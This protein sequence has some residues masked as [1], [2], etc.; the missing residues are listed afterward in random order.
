MHAHLLDRLC[1]ISALIL[2]SPLLAFAALGIKLTS[3]GPVLYHARRVGL[4]G[5]EFTMYKF[6]TMKM[7]KEQ[8]S[9]VTHSH[10]DRIFPFGSFLRSTKIDEL[11]Q[12]WNIVIGQMCIVGPRPED[13]G[14]V[15]EHYTDWQKEVLSVTPGLTSPGSLYDY[16]HG[17]FLVSG[18]ASEDIYLSEVMPRLLALEIVYLRSR[19][20]LTDLGMIGRTLAVILA[21]STGKRHFKLP[22]EMPAALR[23]L[24][25]AGEIVRP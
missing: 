10:D 17:R 19:S 8:G 4:H 9:P 25:Q 6:R 14:I 11:P 24:Q 18:D 16:T 22:R 13:P 7:A 1:A 23:F 21:I 12:L 3:R 5:D 20:V 15:R 2:L